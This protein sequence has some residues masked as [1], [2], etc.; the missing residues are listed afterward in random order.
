MIEGFIT[1]YLLDFAIVFLVGMVSKL[2]ISKFGE[3][4]ASKIK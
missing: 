2:M 3:D 1:K 4:R